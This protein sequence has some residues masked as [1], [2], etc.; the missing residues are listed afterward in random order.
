MCSKC[1]CSADLAFEK[2]KQVFKMPIKSDKKHDR[3]VKNKI[4]RNTSWF[5]S[6]TWINCHPQIDISRYLGISRDIFLGRTPRCFYLLQ[7]R[8]ARIPATTTGPPALYRVGRRASVAPAATEPR[9]ACT[10]E[11]AAPP[12]PVNAYRSFLSISAAS[13]RLLSK[14]WWQPFAT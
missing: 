11:E 8:S 2:I 5:T 13:A 1:V 3:T 12:R 10:R 7:T 9:R 14:A 6:C 4:G